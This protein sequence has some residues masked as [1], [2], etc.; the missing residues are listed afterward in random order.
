MTLGRRAFTLSTLATALGAV[1]TTVLARQRR[2]EAREE[3]PPL[4]DFVETSR[5]SLHFVQEGK[6]PDL[7]LLHGAGGNLREF[8]FDMLPRLTD[9]YRV[10]VFDRPGLGYSDRAG[11]GD[12]PRLATQGDS[13]MEQAAMLREGCGALGV[14]TPI[15]LGHSYGGVVCYAWAISALD[16]A[17]KAN[18]AALV[19]LAGVTMPWPGELGLYY[20]VNGSALGG[21]LAVPLLSAFVPESVVQER[22]RATFAPQDMPDGYYDYIGAD[23]TLRPSTLRENVRQVN[24]LLP[25]VVEFSQ[26]YPDLTLPIEIVHGEAD[27]TVPI[28]IHAEEIIKVA[29]TARLTRLPGVGHMP[30]HANPTETVAA[31]DRAAERAGLR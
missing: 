29:P 20:R 22:V 9:R 3:Y 18:P 27:T 17:H 30:H 5:G 8:T 10:T 26:R 28:H 15:I 12:V 1:G 13:P 11:A 14:E 6:G 4:G 21:A 2:A 7:V 31:I 19:S 23:L 24:T 25:H 16:D